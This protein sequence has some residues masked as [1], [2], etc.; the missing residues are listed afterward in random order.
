M[1]KPRLARGRLF[2]VYFGLAV[3]WAVI[4]AR[5]VQIQ[6]HL[7]DRALALAVG[8]V[9]GTVVLPALR[10]RITDRNGRVLATH[11][12]ELTFAAVPSKWTEQEATKAAKRFAGLGGKSVAQWSA[13]FKV[14]SRFVYV[15]RWADPVTARK[16]R[17]W[18]DPAVF[19]IT[20]PGRLYP[21]GGTGQELLGLVDVD[22]VGQA[23]VEKAWNNVLT[24]QSASA[25]VELD[26]RRQVSL[27]PVPSSLAQDGRNL[28]LTVDWEWQSVIEAVLDSVVQA[29]GA[30]GGGVILMT[31]EGAIRAIAYKANPKYP[32]Y[33][34]SGRCRPISDLF[35]P[36][37][38][39]KVVTA[40]AL[41]AEEKVTLGD[42]VYADSGV[43]QFGN[44]KIRDSEP[45]LWL[46]FAE[47][48]VVSS[49]IAFGKWAQR[50]DGTDWFRWVHDFGFGETTDLGLPAEPQGLIPRHEIWTELHKAQLAMGHSIAVTPLQMLCAFA[51]LANGGDLY[52][53]YL[54][55]A[56]TSPH[57]DTLDVGRPIKL[58]HLLP[59]PVVEQMRS[60]LVRVVT[61]GTA[62]PAHS[63]VID[64]AGK[65]GTA[66]KVREDGKGYHQDRFMSSFVGYFP[67]DQPQVVGMVY[68]DE[69]RTL[70]YGGY[71]AAPAFTRMAER[72]AALD[73]TLL[74]YPQPEEGVVPPVDLP[75]P[76]MQAGVLPDLA[77]LP[78]ARA[79]I[80]ASLCGFVVET[81]GTGLVVQQSPEAGTS[82]DSVRSVRL[83]AAISLPPDSTETDSALT[84]A[85]ED[86]AR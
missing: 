33:A 2:L 15:A 83:V 46:S 39:F 14:S 11:K 65:T 78:L 23:G 13:R 62:K 66:Q 74:R 71:T 81:E 52:R 54:M 56:I 8:Q 1:K 3:C 45:H 67:A 18:N 72:L 60:I 82:L 20:E 10:G 55:A 76:A 48:F 9:E 69:P 4:S 53:P 6:V 68:L 59:R 63:K 61:E 24:G 34:Y 31:P 35:E 37:S 41:L 26:A 77:G 30:K 12:P 25:R 47:S 42:M 5:L 43:C 38:I 86:G 17:S 36:G 29:T 27:V 32:E 28:H 84:V 51:P 21:T 19:E 7:H 16:V 49:N 79:V 50:L 40:A 22:G 70:H 73:P 64:V 75:N 57:G 44:R 58:R 80:C 85:L